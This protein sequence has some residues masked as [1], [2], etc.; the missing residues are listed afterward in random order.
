M[1]AY[2]A[3]FGTKMMG[4]TTS[5]DAPFDQAK[6]DYAYYAAAIN[7]FDVFSHGE[8]YF[9]ASSASLPYRNRPEIPGTAF[10][11]PVVNDSG[12]IKRALNVGLKIDT[13]NHQTSTI[14]N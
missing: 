3:T 6:F 5:S 12:V 7:G 14:L 1:T 2:K 10:V 4:T 13:V 11:G 8:Q 9:S